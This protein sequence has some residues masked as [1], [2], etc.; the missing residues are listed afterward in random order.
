VIG[1]A[2]RDGHAR[3]GEFDQVSNEP[4]TGWDA[5]LIIG[6]PPGETR[7]GDQLASRRRILHLI[8]PG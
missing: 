4:R 3:L 5:H 6:G 2:C 7:S 1:A 8:T